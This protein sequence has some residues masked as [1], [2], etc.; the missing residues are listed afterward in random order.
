MIAVAT[1]GCPLTAAGA[2][3]FLEASPRCALGDGIR[4]SGGLFAQ[5]CV[6]LSLFG[7]PLWVA[8]ARGTWG[9]GQRT[10]A[11]LIQPGPFARQG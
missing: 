1:G 6:K 8:P 10:G 7:T 4:E 5:L 2:L 11:R 3:T 9:R